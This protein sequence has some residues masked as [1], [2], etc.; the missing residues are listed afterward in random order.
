VLVPVVAWRPQ[1][2]REEAA[3]DQVP[4]R[5]TQAPYSAAAA[6]RRRRRRRRRLSQVDVHELEL[7]LLMMMVCGSRRQRLRLGGRRLRHRSRSCVEDDVQELE[8]A[9][10]RTGVDDCT[11]PLQ[12]PACLINLLIVN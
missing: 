4:D 1:Q 10:V 5:T 9:H 12:L 6:C 8:Y 11:V 2:T 7:A 3:D